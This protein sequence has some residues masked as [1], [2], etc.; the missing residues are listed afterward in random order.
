MRP[1]PD[2]RL[3]R[4]IRGLDQVTSQLDDLH[5]EVIEILRDQDVTWADIADCYQ[6][7]KS[8]QALQKWMATRRR[9]RA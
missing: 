5:A 8:R 4:V 1:D 9:R 7:T 3:A 2:P 6:P